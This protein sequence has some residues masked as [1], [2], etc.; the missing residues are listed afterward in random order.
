[1]Q[2]LPSSQDISWFLDQYSRNQLNLSPPY[3]RRS[4]WTLKDRKFFIDSIIRGYPCPPIF[5][6][7]T[8]SD[9]GATTYH[10]ID[11]KQRL[12]TII[13]F[14][15][16]EFSI[17]KEFGD[18]ELNGKKWRELN[19]NHKRNFWNYIIPVEFIDI[20]EGNIV[21]EIFDRFNR[22]ARK[23]ERQE[24]RH[25]RFD[26][27]FIRLVEAESEKVEWK[28]LGIVT[29][30][31]AKRMKDSQFI[32]ELLLV[33]LKNQVLGF[34]QDFLDESY[35]DY[36]TPEDTIQNFSEDEF[37]K[38]LESVKDYL[39]EVEKNSKS[40]TKFAKSFA[41]FYSLWCL[42]SLHQAELPNVDEFASKYTEFMMAVEGSGTSSNELTSPYVIQYQENVVGAS[43]DLGPRQARHKALVTSL[44]A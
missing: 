32:S 37:V 25:A 21:N 14:T 44:L 9:E 24:L 6:H 18:S 17:D 8:I 12:E 26:G 38:K 4:V 33:I 34:D 23:L 30:S 16:S 2:R 35:R 42:V 22:N 13:K 29:S 39:I 40:V 15:K 10:V 31:R 20:V 19:Q 11:G 43:T 3:Q 28:N 27:W 41:N 5:L 36:D 1:M 7:K